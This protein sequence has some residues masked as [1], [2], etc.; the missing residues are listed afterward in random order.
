MLNRHTTALAACLTLFAAAT[1]L[2]AWA[3]WKCQING[4][5]VFQNE[6]CPGGKP[7]APAPAADPDEQARAAAQAAHDRSQRN[8]LQTD[9]AKR[10]AQEARENA[11]NA[12]LAANQKRKKQLCQQYAQQQKWAEEDARRAAGPKGDQLR[13]QVRRSAERYQLQC[14]AS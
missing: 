13:S 9:R 7:L 8:E 3:I 1:P 14:G 4:Q 2:P 5:T 6:A 12:R 11:K 10:E